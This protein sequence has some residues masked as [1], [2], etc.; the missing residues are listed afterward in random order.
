ML[1]QLPHAV[2]RRR[3]GCGCATLDLAVDRSAAPPAAVGNSSVV[4]SASFSV[5]G[6]SD[7]DGVLL[8]AEDGYLSCLEVY[9][10]ADEPI[11]AW[12]DPRL[13]ELDARD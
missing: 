3:C 8:F 4:A 10:V 2:V 9:S 7:T 12:P 5:D 11:R 13:L 6:L 1:C